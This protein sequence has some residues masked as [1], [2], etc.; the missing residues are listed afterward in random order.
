VL[1]GSRMLA[2]LSTAVPTARTVRGG[3]TYAAASQFSAAHKQL[4]PCLLALL[5]GVA[6]GTARYNFHRSLMM[7][8]RLRVR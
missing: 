8:R 3:R 4:L 7:E 6:P 2:L 1:V 5:S